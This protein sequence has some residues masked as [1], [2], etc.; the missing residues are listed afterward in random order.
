MLPLY[1]ELTCK[2]NLKYDDFQNMY[3]SSICII[4]IVLLL[5]DNNLVSLILWHTEYELLC[6]KDFPLK[7]SE[8]FMKLFCNIRAF[9]NSNE[10]VSILFLYHFRQSFSNI[11][12]NI[13][14]LNFFL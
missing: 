3:N 7:F 1:Y 4:N 10:E 11:F 8:E 14:L 5:F 9:L 12:K 2:V 13:K 6:C